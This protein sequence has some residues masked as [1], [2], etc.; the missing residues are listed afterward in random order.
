[1]LDLFVIVVKPSRAAR[2]AYQV[3]LYEAANELAPVLAAEPSLPAR[4]IAFIPRLTT[5]APKTWLIGAAGVTRRAADEPE[6]TGPIRLTSRL[7]PRATKTRTNEPALNPPLR[8]NAAVGD[9]TCRARWSTESS[10]SRD[11]PVP[12]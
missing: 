4:R 12:V 5:N 1:V 11:L 7:L 8:P 10:L 3:N 6:R 9:R 2:S